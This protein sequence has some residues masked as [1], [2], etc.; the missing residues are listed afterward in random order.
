MSGLSIAQCFPSICTKEP[1]QT[2]NWLVSEIP[3]EE[4]MNMMKLNCD[5]IIALS[6]AY[7]QNAH[8]GDSLINIGSVLGSTSLSGLA[9][10]TG[11]KGFI[12]R[13]SESLW[14]EYKKRGIYVCVFSPGVTSSNFYKAVKSDVDVYPKAIQQTPEQVAKELSKALHQRSKPHIV[15]G[16]MNR[17]MLFF[18]R[19]LTRKAI[20]NMMGGF[21][22]VK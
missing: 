8:Q 13:F 17:S 6:H 20:V 1:Q 9:V 18:Y 5:A 3:L 15:S 2:L 7:L 16:F 12:V 10:Y 22:T 11:T 19:L 21:S 4:Q 14:H